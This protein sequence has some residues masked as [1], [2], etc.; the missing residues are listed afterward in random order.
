MTQLNNLDKYEDHLNYYELYSKNNNR[1]NE[2]IQKIIK[3]YNFDYDPA[4]YYRHNIDSVI[5]RNHYEIGGII[6]M[7]N[8]II[9]K[10]FYGY[11]IKTGVK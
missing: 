11:C 6:I 4:K 9:D 10:T 1:L 3:T 5:T 8:A 7:L 2:I